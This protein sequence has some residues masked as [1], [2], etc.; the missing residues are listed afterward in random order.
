MY[1]ILWSYSL[2]HLLPEPLQVSRPGC[3]RFDLAIRTVSDPL[4]AM[5]PNI[6]Y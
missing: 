6:T 2:L 1:R 3:G 4:S 5:P